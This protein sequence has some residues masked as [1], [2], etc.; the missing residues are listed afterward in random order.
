M[1]KNTSKAKYLKNTEREQQILDAACTLFSEKSYDSVSVRE[2]ADACNCSA[3]LIMKVF[4]S[5]EAIYAALFSEWQNM[6][7]DPLVKEIPEGSACIALKKIFDML[8]SGKDDRHVHRSNLE[9]AIISRVSYRAAV[10]DVRKDF[11]D[12]S[13]E[14]ILPLIIRGQQENQIRK[15]DSK[16]I[17]DLFWFVVYGSRLINKSF[18]VF[19]T[20]D[21]NLVKEF[22]L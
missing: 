16:E 7:K 5:K 1:K 22:I 17:A 2:I 12:V 15:G 21:F 20:V 18:S 11:Q 4:K 13:T 14:I 19:K 8:T 10:K 9:N 3:A 6:C